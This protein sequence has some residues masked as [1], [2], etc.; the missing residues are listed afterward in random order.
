MNSASC[1]IIKTLLQSCPPPCQRVPSQQLCCPATGEGPPPLLDPDQA[2]LE[3]QGHATDRS[4]MAALQAAGQIGEL[5][6]K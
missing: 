4:T 5:S 6:K 2:R 3:S 1:Y